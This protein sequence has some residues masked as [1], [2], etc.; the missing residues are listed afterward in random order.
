ME[1]FEKMSGS[2]LLKKQTT[3]THSTPRPPSTQA[4]TPAPHPG[5]ATPHAPHDHPNK[6]ILH[7]PTPA[8]LASS[9]HQDAA[10]APIPHRPPPAS[11][12]RPARTTRSPPAG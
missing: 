11:S 12:P 5:A 10:R 8:A 1:R 4:Q 9:T 2:T 6:E 3:A 7:P